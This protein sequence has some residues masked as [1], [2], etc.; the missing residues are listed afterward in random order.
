MDEIKLGGMLHSKKLRGTLLPIK[1]KY[2]DS[3]VLSYKFSKTIGESLFNY[4]LI[5]S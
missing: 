2:T 5:R 3:I 4:S 1:L